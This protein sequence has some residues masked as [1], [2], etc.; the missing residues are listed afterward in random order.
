[1]V[2]ACEDGEIG[3][4]IAIEVADDDGYGRISHR[5]RKGRT[6]SGYEL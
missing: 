3:N 5:Q 4:S 1:V 6:G 2:E